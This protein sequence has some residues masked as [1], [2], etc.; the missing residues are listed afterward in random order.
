[1]IQG[2][3]DANP[4]EAVPLV[5]EYEGR[6]RFKVLPAFDE[7]KRPDPELARFDFGTAR[8][9]TVAVSADGEVLFT[10]PGHEYGRD[11]IVAK[12]DAMLAR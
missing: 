4:D 7:E 3:R 10:I 9:G 1:V 8:H 5:Q 12:I 11:E 2:S 6:V